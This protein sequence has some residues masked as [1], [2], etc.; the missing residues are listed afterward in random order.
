MTEQTT[1][2]KVYRY[3]GL[4]AYEREELE[5]VIKLAEA[6]TDTKGNDKYEF[7]AWIFHDRDVDLEKNVLK[8]PHYHVLL[9]LTQD[10]SNNNKNITVSV[11]AKKLQVQKN[12]I[13]I[14][15]CPYF[16]YHVKY[17]IHKQP[18][19][20]ER[21]QYNPEEIQVVRNRTGKSIEDYLTD[22]TE[23]KKNLNY[24]INE[25]VNNR[26]TLEDVFEEDQTLFCKKLQILERAEAKRV[27]SIIP[28]TRVCY[29]I[30]GTSG[31]GKTTLAKLLA[32]GLFLKDVEKHRIIDNKNLH[33]LMYFTGSKNV[34]FDKYNHQKVM[35]FDDVRNATIKDLGGVEEAFKLFNNQPNSEAFNKKFG[36]VVINSE[37]MFL[38]NVEDIHTFVSS[39]MKN[40]PLQIR[41][42]L[43]R[44]LPVIIEVK[45]KQIVFKVSNY[46]LSQLDKNYK[47][48]REHHIYQTVLTLNT[49]VLFMAKN[50]SIQNIKKITKDFLKLHKA[51]KKVFK[52]DNRRKPGK[53]VKE[54]NPIAAKIFK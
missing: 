15:E 4:V 21:G 16:G 49:D 45:R 5:R 18:K 40:E 23:I 14:L 30:T 7:I 6:D 28:E 38:T 35:I 48:G 13:E 19:F 10:G 9:K 33:K 26:M 53:V 12:M 50:E 42:Q 39:V 17:L 20:Q 43:Y 36:N 52:R 29:Y 31:Q 27:E 22:N 54:I 1:K 37:V 24:Y 34:A 3:I 2:E 46:I 32:K 41:N 51:I 47:G 44:R 8:K 11:A 25:I